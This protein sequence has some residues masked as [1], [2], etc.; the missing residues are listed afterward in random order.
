MTRHFGR[1]LGS[2]RTRLLLLAVLVVVPALVLVA[3]G[4]L[5]LRRQVSEQAQADA[6][7]L[8]RLGADEHRQLVDQTRQ[9]LAALAQ[10][11]AAMAAASDPST[12]SRLMGRVLQEQGGYTNLGVINLDGTM[13][14]SAQ[15]VDTTI[16]VA[17]RQYF[18][19]VVQT[20]AFAIGDVAAGRVTG[21]PTIMLAGPVLG[22]RGELV[23]VIHAGLDLAWLARFVAT[24]DLPS[25]ARMALIRADGTVLARA[26]DPERLAGQVLPHDVLAERLAGGRGSTGEATGDDG[27]VRLFAV[28]PADPIVGDGGSTGRIWVTGAI[29]TGT[30]LAR[31]D[32]L[33]AA[34]LIVLALTVGLVLVLA[35]VGSDVLLLGKLRLL[36]KVTRQLERGELS[37]RSGLDGDPTE[38]GV[39]ARD[40]DLLATGLEQRE[41]ERR[42]AAEALRAREQQLQDESRRLLA[43]H[44][45]ST[46]LAAQ[47]GTRDA[48]LQEILR[49]AVSLV[50]A[51]SGSLFR[52]DAEAGLLRCLR[53][54]NV[55]AADPTPDTRPGEGLVGQAFVGLTA[56]VV[57]DYR[58]WE[59]ALPV[60]VQAGLQTALGIPLRHAGQS[61]G[62]LVLCCYRAD[63]PDFSERDARLASLFGDQAAA[64]MENAHLYAGLAVQVER[65]RSLTRL[66]EVISSTLD[67]VAVLR[68]IAHAAARLFGAPMVAFWT[69]DEATRRL[70]VSACTDDQSGAGFPRDGLAIGEGLAGWVAAHRQPL[71]VADVLADPRSTSFLTEKRRATQALR[72]FYGVP[73]IHEGTLLAVLVLNGH[74]PFQFGPE[75]H[76]LLESFVAQAA[77]AMRNASLYASVAETNL[78][79]EESVVRANEL[80]VAAQDADRAKSEFLATMSHEIR[81]PMNGVIGMTEL[82]LDTDLDEEQRDLADTIRSSADSL[83]GIINDILD[84]SRIEAGRLDVESVPCNVRQVVEDVADLVAESAHR[85]GLELVTFVDPALPERLIGDPGRLRQIVLNLAANAVKF[86]EWGEVVLWTGVEHEDEDAIVVR[87]EVRDTG[88][89]I[90][91]EARPRLFQPFS[92]ADSSTTRRYGGTGLGLVISKR[93]AEMMGGQIGFESTPGMGS[94]FWVTVRLVRGAETSAHRFPNILEGLRAL[95][96]VQNPT[97]RTALGRQ[98][99]SWGIGVESVDSPALVPERLLDAV[100]DGAPFDVLVLDE[101]MPTHLHH[102]TSLGRSN[103]VNAILERLP[104]VVLTRRGT[105]AAPAPSSGPLTVSLSRPVRQR[106]LFAAVARAVKRA[107]V[108]E[109][110]LLD[111][112]LAPTQGPTL[113]SPPDA[114][115]V[116]ILVAE[117]NSVNQEV[118]RRLLARLGCTV[119]VVATG[120]DAVE[121]SA[122]EAYAA[123]LMD[124]QMPEL[125]GYEA[126]AAIRAREAADR[127]GPRIPIIALTASAMPGDRERCLA[128]GMNDYLAKPMTLDRLADVLR[129]WLPGRI[130]APTTPSSRAGHQVADRAGEPVLDVSVLSQLANGDLGGD[131]AFVVELID[132][133]VEQIR[134]LMADLG[135]ATDA[136]DR[137]TVARIAH[138]LQSSAGNLGARRLQRLCAEV[139]STAQ[140]SDGA[141]V[142]EGVEA[143]LAEIESVL[144]ALALERQRAAA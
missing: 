33:L 135:V 61:V 127:D 39:L 35:W 31:V 57:N 100:A 62:V 60:S 66:N 54:W 13:V 12:C 130:I 89:G 40:L 19:R 26:P 5:V 21:R 97:H 22:P 25:G 8:A 43:L 48:I 37:T 119:Q 36:Q 115:P 4:G 75:D 136:D 86:T 111:G 17:D 128:A 34:G 18:Q 126:T 90:A 29:P 52:W 103:A 15:P 58:H 102:A 125:D 74:Q 56:V 94:T 76:D 11:P 24:A 63:V 132:L 79:L 50:G 14:C 92:Q 112:K 1:Y 118:A 71:S 113:P 93:L 109:P 129:R 16:N 45:A 139:E 23:G 70:H 107:R 104:R 84:F 44:D 105:A 47:S 73:V 91:P 3:V 95:L 133:F 49:S 82:L 67:R 27:V 46:A 140:A 42:D 32:A 6:L 137:Q 123:I 78:A 81:T 121:A 124:C 69:V 30:A 38:L 64:A 120:V 80:A 138:T 131:P 114:G 99:A 116:S 142:R 2:I 101:Q 53:S 143:M 77:V 41:G 10:H 65:L 134:P 85:K 72:S 51:D 98:V 20:G 110:R 87:F 122:R 83:L 7:R 68:E 96:V 117:D 144:S 108:A 9:L 88:V 141:S 59:Y 55:P 106:Q 28:A